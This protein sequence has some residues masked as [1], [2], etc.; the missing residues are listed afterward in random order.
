MK[1]FINL[2]NIKNM[3]TFF[4]AFLV[5]AFLFFNTV[6]FSANAGNG[7]KGESVSV[8]GSLEIVTSHHLYELAS[9]WS[10]GYMEENPEAQITISRH[11][12]DFS[13]SEGKIYFLTSNQFSDFKE[14]P[15]LKMLVG[16]EITV[17][18][19]NSNNPW[20]EN[21]YRKG[22]TEEHFAMFS[23]GDCSWSDLLKDGGSNPVTFYMEDDP[24]MISKLAGFTNAGQ[25]DIQSRKV[26]S[27]EELV[28]LVQQDVY[29]VGFCRLTDIINSEKNAF[30]DN[31]S[32]IPIDKNR[33]GVLDRFEHIYSNPEE[34]TRG[35]WVGKYPRSLCSD[36]YAFSSE[37]PEDETIKNFLAWVIDDGQHELA[38]LG[39]SSLST[40]EKTAGMLALD[41]SS[42]G[43]D[44]AASAPLIPLGW[45]I[46]AGAAVVILLLVILIH[47]KSKKR[48]GL[49]SEDIAITSALNVNS[50]GAPAGLFFDKTHTWAFMEKDGMVK[51][52]IDDFMQHI[53]GAL[54]Q[55]RMKSPGE[56]VRKG[57]KIL[58]IVR[59]GKKL[60]L[61]SPVTGCIKNQNELLLSNPSLINSDPYFNGWVY[62]IEP[63]NWMRETRFMFM[64]DKFQDW[65]EDEFT[66]LK[67][68][69]ASSANSNLVVYE[70][71][72][73]QDGGELTDNVL[74]DMG[75]EIWED[76]QTHFIDISK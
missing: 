51:I 21:I 3:K 15:G 2:I 53:T 26:S 61:Y 7:Q 50:I 48:A 30:V 33:N 75:P 9:A 64:A 5:L 68:F 19:M 56:K 76:F 40:R 47:G 8:P 42:P 17:P 28:S 60:D 4:S 74:A 71:I 58:T 70:H 25:A 23:S 39:L 13:V 67:D 34:L 59:E 41:H 46:A 49:L 27:A 57:E 10:S 45:I 32:I 65:L 69:L 54:S 20:L 55:I 14:Q 6:N 72:V 66:R 16:H 52:G 38:S 73:L 29:A 18:V 35:V 62:Q 36:V 43:S 63:S 11:S 37:I 22:F 12:G 44:F 24:Q 31:I 1:S